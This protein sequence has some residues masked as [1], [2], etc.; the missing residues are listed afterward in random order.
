MVRAGGRAAWAALAGN[1][2]EWVVRMQSSFVLAA[3]ILLSRHMPEDTGRAIAAM[4]RTLTKIEPDHEAV[5]P[6]DGQPEHT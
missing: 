2:E 3:Q 6:G 4:V 1:A 5:K